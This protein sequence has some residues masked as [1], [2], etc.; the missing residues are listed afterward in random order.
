MKRV[1]PVGRS[2]FGMSG[3]TTDANRLYSVLLDSRASAVSE[4]MYDIAEKLM[5]G[6]KENSK[7]A[8][9]QLWALR[10]N[11]QEEDQS[12]TV[13]LLIE[14]YQRK[15]DVLR[16]RE[17][18]IKKVSRDSRELLEE[19]RK[20]DAETATVKQEMID[21]SGEIERLHTKLDH[22]KV[23][24]QELRLIDEQVKRELQVNANEVVN[25]LY[26]IVVVDQQGEG[27]SLSVEEEIR[28]E[29]SRGAEPE[30]GGETTGENPAAEAVAEVETE[31]PSIESEHTREVSLDELRG[32]KAM[33]AVRKPEAT[34]EAGEETQSDGIFESDREGPVSAPAGSG[35][36]A[37][38]EEETIVPYPK[39]VVK[40]T[41]GFVIGEYYYDPKVYKNKRN[42]IF[43]SDFLWRHLSRA[44][45]TLN[46]SF[47]RGTY[48]EVVQTIQD[49]YKRIKE[50]PN[51]HF[52][53][54][55]NEILNEDVLK[56]L[57]QHMKQRD[58][59]E[60]L[61]VCNRLKAKIRALGGNYVMMLSEQMARLG[62]DET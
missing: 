56:S 37:E 9:E 25:G 15:I 40:T 14:F 41:H 49:A 3:S 10:K 30:A 35:K 2:V 51:L 5:T 8:L 26:E 42:Y 38:P 36:P 16:N 1:D 57:W 47:D 22:L 18:H 4:N 52:E 27:P 59:N 44:L 39:S 32:D 7:L 31:A 55:T 29:E 58:Y 48:S 24:E 60:V 50:K 53:I 62:E 43:N 19:K 33:T 13:D 11:L 28:P 45:L 61:V 23:K 21:C 12:G 46:E 17:E 54:S 20:R 6:E 34:A